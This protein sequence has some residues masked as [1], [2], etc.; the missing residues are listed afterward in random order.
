MIAGLICGLYGVLCFWLGYCMRYMS[1]KP[2][3]K[4]DKE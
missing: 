3:K 4:G 1:E 2:N